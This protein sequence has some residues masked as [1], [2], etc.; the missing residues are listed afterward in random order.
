[1][2]VF[3]SSQKIP[4]RSWKLDSKLLTHAQERQSFV[5]CRLALGVRGVW[6]LTY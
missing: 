3:E 4:E 5:D 6:P 2:G 1:M